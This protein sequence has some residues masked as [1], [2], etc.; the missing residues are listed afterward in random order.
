MVWR[1]AT[2][3]ILKRPTGSD[4]VGWHFKQGRQTYV[5][6]TIYHIDHTNKQVMEK[7]SKFVES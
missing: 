3:T 5:A 7:P 1:A 4:F 2:L 6:Q